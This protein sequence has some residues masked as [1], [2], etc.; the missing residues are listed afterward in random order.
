[1]SQ[2][3]SRGPSPRS[4]GVSAGRD[5][6]RPKASPKQLQFRLDISTQPHPLQ[7]SSQPDLGPSPSLKHTGNCPGP[8]PNLRPTAAAAQP[9]SP[10]PRQP[11][12]CS[13]LCLI[14]TSIPARPEPQGWPVA[15]SGQGRGVTRWF[16]SALG[17]DTNDLLNT[18]NVP[19]LLGAGDISVNM[20]VALGRGESP[21]SPPTYTWPLPLPCLPPSFSPILPPFHSLHPF[22]QPPSFPSLPQFPQSPSFLPP[23][24]LSFPP[25]SSFQSQTS[26]SL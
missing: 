10:T 23:L 11:E 20:R 3:L 2:W 1:M 26:S 21:N 18:S 12:S 25:V 13:Q 14:L 5:L 22:P 7:P 19:G 17:S 9:E 15:Y 16:S 4:S 6:A 8:R 24:P